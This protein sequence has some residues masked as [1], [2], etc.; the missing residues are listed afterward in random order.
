MLESALDWVSSLS[1]VTFLRAFWFGLIFELPR[2]LVPSL[3][4]TAVTLFPFAPRRGRRRGAPGGDRVTVLV[5]GHNEGDSVRRCIHSLHEQTLKGFEIICVSD[6]STD[7]MTAEVRQLEREGRID[8]ALSVSLRGGKVA[9]VNLAAA[10]SARDILVIVDC[11]SSLD[12]DCLENLI[13]PFAD[14]L[15]GAVSGAIYA[16]NH[17][18]SL[19][20]SFQAIEYLIGIGLGK[21]VSDALGQS[22]CAS[23]ALSAFRKHVMVRVGAMDATGGED[24]EF[25]LRVREAGF[26]VRFVPEAVCYTDVPESLAALLRQRKRWEGD[27]IDVRFRVHGY[28]MNPLD[29][30]FRLA[31]CYHQFEFLIFTALASCIFPFYVFYL[32][33]KFGEHAPVFLF[34]VLIVTTSADL[35]MF[36][37]ANLVAERHARWE[38]LGVCVLYGAFQTFVMRFHRAITYFRETFLLDTLKDPYRPAKVRFKINKL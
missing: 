30:R 10:L 18:R 29:S 7:N 35:F 16:R 4:V 36:V 1:T 23:G 2:Y 21:R 34:G 32:F 3:I 31:E 14:P 17:R 6:G 33:A 37:L 28:T 13:A 5:I 24:F 38:L 11:D 9:G 27:A 12:R 15:V 8:R 25:T 26:K 22:T 19:I 20:S